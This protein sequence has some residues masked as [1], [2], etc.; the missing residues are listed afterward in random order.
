[1][2]LNAN[3]MHKYG[4]EAGVQ[5]FRTFTWEGECSASCCNNRYH[6]EDIFQMPVM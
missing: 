5:D 2:Q 4:R 1:M 3:V 6:I